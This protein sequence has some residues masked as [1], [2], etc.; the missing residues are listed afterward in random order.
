MIK[1]ALMVGI[2]KYPGCPLQG[3][4]ND[5]HNV[6]AVLK[7]LDFKLENVKFMLDSDA[8]TANILDA[9]NWLKDG[10]V[11]GDTVLFDY[12]GHGATVPDT[13]GDEPDGV[14]N[15]ICPVD[16]DFTPEHMI[17]DKQFVKI[18]STLPTGVIFNWISDSCHSGHLSREMT[19]HVPRHFPVPLEI[20]RDINSR[21]A[22]GAVS[23][24]MVAGHLDVGYV[25]GCRS[26]QT[27][28]D[29]VI[30]GKPAGALTGYFLKEYKNSPKAPLVQLVLNTSMALEKDG[31]KQKPKA[32][33]AR[34]R[35]PFLG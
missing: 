4:V 6:G 31:Y 15:C 5:V 24:G 35:M 32:D 9:L 23:R 10:I 8:T 26:K 7:T 21:L 16:F 27:S 25:A 28:A 13:D 14:H 20:A 33:G 1:K 18:F 30:D 22:R 19:L 17:I 2:N 29:T 3:C 34:V 12:S 11:G